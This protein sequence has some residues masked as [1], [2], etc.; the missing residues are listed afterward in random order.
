MCVALQSRV[1]ALLRIGL[2]LFKTCLALLRTGL[3]PL[4]TCL[5]LLRTGWDLPSTDQDWSSI[6]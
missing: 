5:A 3:A 2:A 6:A 1:V 4:G